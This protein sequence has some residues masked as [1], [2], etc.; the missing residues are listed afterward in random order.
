MLVVLW[1][2][3]KTKI[4][5]RRLKLVQLLGAQADKTKIYFSNIEFNHKIFVE[6]YQFKKFIFYGDCIKSSNRPGNIIFGILDNSDTDAFE[7]LLC[8]MQISSY[9]KYINSKNNY[10]L[11]DACR[12]SNS[13]P[14]KEM[15]RMMIDKNLNIL[16]CFQGEILGRFGNNLNEVKNNYIKHWRE[17]AKN[18]GCKTCSARDSCSQCPFLGDIDPARYCEIKRKYS[19][20]INKFIFLLQSKTAM[21]L[22]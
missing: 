19:M 17:E 16:P 1:G 11:L 21:Q 14:A 13:C 10:I 20:L 9:E 2:K 4:A 18:R 8:R 5:I 15:K 22:I 6:E 12:W 3:G 7:K